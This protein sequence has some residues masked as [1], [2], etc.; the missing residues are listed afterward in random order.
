MFIFVCITPLHTHTHIHTYIHNTYIYMHTHMLEYKHTYIYMACTH[1]KTCYPDSVVIMGFFT[2]V[3]RRPGLPPGRGPHFREEIRIVATV[4]CM[5]WGV[6]SL[7]RTVPC[8]YFGERL[9]VFPPPQVLLPPQSR[10]FRSPEV[11]LRVFLGAKSA[12]S[13]EWC[14]EFTP[15]QFVCFMQ[16]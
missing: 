6:A 5:C 7:K 11:V 16:V 10:A 2:Y 1:M 12:L 4:L 9:P 14:L 8:I 15:A 3:G 13:T